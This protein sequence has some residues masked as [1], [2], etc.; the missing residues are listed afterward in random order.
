[1]EEKGLRIKF[2]RQVDSP[3]SWVVCFSSFV[4]QFLILGTHNSFGSFF[5]ALLEEFHRSEAETAWIGSLAVGITY[6]A[7]PISTSLCDRWGCRVVMCLGSVTYMVAMLITSFVPYM[8]FMYLTYGV[9]FGF[10]SSCCYFSSFYVLI[11]YFNK[12]LALANG[13]AA[14]GAGAGTMSISL[15]VDKLIASFGLRTT[16]Q[17]MAGLSVLLFVAGLT[18]MPIDFRDEDELFKTKVVMKEREKIKILD[19]LAINIKRLL[20]PA[21]VWKNKAF[22]AWTVAMAM[23]LFA[24]YIPYVYLVRLAEGIGVPSTQGALL[25]G[26]FALAQTFGKIT[27]GKL[28]DS[29]RISRLTLTQIALLVMAVAACL[30][31]LAQSHTALLTYSLVSGLFDGCLCVMVGL[32]THD[33]VGRQMMAKAVGTMYGIVAIPMTVGPPMAGLLYDSTGSYDIVFFLSSGLVVGGSCI[34]FLIPNLLPSTGASHKVVIPEIRVTSDAIIE[35]DD[36]FLGDQM[37]KTLSQ[38]SLQ[39]FGHDMEI[40]GSRLLL[41]SENL[42]SRPNSFILFSIVPEAGS[43][44]DLSVANER[45]SSSTEPSFT[46]LARVSEIRIDSRINSC[47]KLET[48]KEME[49]PDS[50]VVSENFNSKDLASSAIDLD[51]K[52]LSTYSWNSTGSQLS[53]KTQCSEA[54]TDDSGYVEETSSCQNEGNRQYAG[55]DGKINSF[56]ILERDSAVESRDCNCDSTLCRKEKG[57]DLSGREYD[58]E[59][60]V[61][62]LKEGPLVIDPGS[63]KSVESFSFCACGED[64]SN[65]S[66]KTIADV[67]ET[68][69]QKDS[70]ISFPPTPPPD[71]YSQFF[72][73]ILEE[74]NDYVESGF[75]DNP[76]FHDSLKWWSNVSLTD[77]KSCQRETMV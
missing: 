65:V 4:V 11:I 49:A 26:Y 8:S 59:E 74:V 68:I 54:D 10:A 14:A 15:I 75:S 3:W 16:F 46:S 25:V 45:Y 33:I 53:W 29:E 71:I 18:F 56:E 20:R 42:N 77:V 22:V 36:S 61:H 50:C 70:Y 67:K 12:Y 40:D 31:P 30:C 28:G 60:H 35:L 51:E 37:H 2:H 9:L 69:N 43:F 44:R 41:G 39:S 24:N 57:T 47:A 13:I 32:V 64:Q 7:A 19:G 38:P 66:A 5:V 72:E 58:T 48:V 76:G 34:M 23:T 52:R 1:M 27:F 21:P 63:F 62:S 6:M 17:G 73:E 55:S